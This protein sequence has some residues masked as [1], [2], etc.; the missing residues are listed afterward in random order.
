M[1]QFPPGTIVDDH[2]EVLS[3]LG[4]GGM[5]VVL[6]VRERELDRILALKVLHPEWLTDC[7]SQQRFVREGKILGTLK[8]PNI[9]T[10]YKLGVSTE[11][12]YIATEF[13]EGEPLSV[14]LARDGK[15]TA[16]RA[17]SIGIQIC[18]ARAYAHEHGRGQ[19]G[20]I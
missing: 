13:I 15:L 9:L 12:A 18:Q 16:D 20:N 19:F 11:F 17:V 4:E 8:H 3:H 7:D 2:Y 5:G 6:K 14:V 10:F 1:H